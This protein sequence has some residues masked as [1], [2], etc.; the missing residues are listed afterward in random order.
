ML[1]REKKKGRGLYAMAW[2]GL[3]WLFW[4]FFLG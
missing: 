4:L 1:G 3:L 2:V